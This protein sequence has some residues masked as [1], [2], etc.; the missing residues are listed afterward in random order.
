MNLLPRHAQSANKSSFG[1]FLTSPGRVLVPTVLVLAIGGAVIV[2]MAVRVPDVDAASL[3]EEPAASDVEGAMIR[4]GLDAEALAASGVST[5][6]VSTLVQNL[7]DHMA[8]MA[9]S[10]GRL[11][12]SVADAR[13]QM[14]RYAERVRAGT[15]SDDDV[16]SLNAA[17]T[18]LATA[19]TRHI[20]FH[21]VMFY[22]TEDTVRHRE[23]VFVYY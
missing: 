1:R 4:L 8:G 12:A 10:L 21:H 14:S 13:A 17:K 23:H 6:E 15:G 18:V 19:E 22:I 16:A 5:A 20:Y 11:D 2:G 9:P 7:A 3:T